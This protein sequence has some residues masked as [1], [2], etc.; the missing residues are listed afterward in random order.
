MTSGDKIRMATYSEL[1]SLLESNS[2]SGIA[3]YSSNTRSNDGD[4][5]VA[6]TVSPLNTI[7]VSSAGVVTTP[8]DGIY[9]VDVLAQGNNNTSNDS[10]ETRY[11]FMYSVNGGVKEELGNCELQFERITWINDYFPA[12]TFGLIHM[13][14]GDTLVISTES[15]EFTSYIQRHQVIIE[16][17]G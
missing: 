9:R 11:S 14:A 6:D 10:D 8:Y 12:A 3:Y 1:E 2:R 15:H 13:S 4:D 5:L 16:Y 17:K 7:S